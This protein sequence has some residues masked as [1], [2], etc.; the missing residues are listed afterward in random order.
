[1]L[2]I[3]F[4]AA[5]TVIS[6]RIF[7]PCCSRSWCHLFII[8]P[9]CFPVLHF[10][11]VRWHF[12][13]WWPGAQNKFLHSLKLI[14]VQRCF[15][16][17]LRVFSVIKCIV[18]VTFSGFF[19]IL[20]CPLFAVFRGWIYKLLQIFISLWNYDKMILK[21]DIHIPLFFLVRYNICSF[22]LSVSLSAMFLF[23]LM[24]FFYQ[25]F[26]KIF[27]LVTEGTTSVVIFFFFSYCTCC[28]VFV[29]LF[30]VRRTLCFS[31]IRLI[32]SCQ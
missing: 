3:L 8:Y 2:L 5:P 13:N 10:F 1:M 15:V 6:A 21:M 26:L 7:C 18:C 20:I 31:I 12:C 28:V 16:C 32:F 14:A 4:F 24:Y 17:W 19:E 9:W 30:S 23:F 22:L 29:R 11:F 25:F 27:A